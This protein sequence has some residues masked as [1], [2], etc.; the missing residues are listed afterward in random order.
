VA[1]SKPPHARPSESL[2]TPA[3][4]VVTTSNSG[5]LSCAMYVMYH[6]WSFCKVMVE[7]IF[8]VLL[9][10]AE[11]SNRYLAYIWKGIGKG[12]EC[13]LPQ[14]LTGHSGGSPMWRAALI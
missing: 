1:W 9:C 4:M 6:F 13:L 5:K 12:R 14:V 2:L 10:C 3:L 8:S 11:V 7:C